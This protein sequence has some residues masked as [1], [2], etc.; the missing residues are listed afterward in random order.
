MMRIVGVRATETTGPTALLTAALAVS[1]AAMATRAG[2]QTPA[3]LTEWQYS[4][5]VPLERLFQPEVPDWRVRLG[6]AFSLRPRYYGADRYQVVGGPSVDIRYRDLFFAST[7][8]GVGVNVLRGPNWRAGIAITYDLGRRAANDPGHLSGLGNINPAPE[9]KLFADYVISKE[10]P[11]VLRADIR[12]NLGG[13]DGWIGDLGAY[14]PLPGSS[15]QFFW[16]GGPT[17]TFA[18]SRYMNRWFGVSP[19]QAAASGYPNY[20]ANPGLKS[21]GAGVTA[22]WY[23]RKHWFMTADVAVQQLVGS[24]AR[25]P[26]TQ[27]STNGVFDFSINYQF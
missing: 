12:R 17:L 21:V 5:G 4:A 15:E 27:V 19:T 1:S 14:L 18:D 22:V 24:A 8:E 16:F 13:T 26:I 23:F 20:H 25:S 9:A 2:A 6:A 10:F 7:G 11:L 3:P